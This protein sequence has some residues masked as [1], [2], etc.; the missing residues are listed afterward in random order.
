MTTAADYL[1]Y[2]KLRAPQ[3]SGEGLFEPAW[4]EIAPLVNENLVTRSE[5]CYDVHGKCLS[6]LAQEAREEMLGAARQWTASYRDIGDWAQRSSDRVFLAGHQPQMYH[7]GVWLKNFAL[8]RLA[9]EHDGVAVNLIVDSDTI[10]S[11]ALRVPGK[12]AE[13][14]NVVEIPYDSSGPMVPF[15]ER[16]ILDRQLF[17]SFSDRVER[18]IDSLVAEPLVGE[19]WRHVQ[20]R[21]RHCDR[22][23]L[24]LAQARHILEGEWGAQTLEL[25]QSVVCDSESYRWFLC[26]M[27]SEASRFRCIH[28]EV[29]AEYRRVHRIRSLA[30]P[31][32]DLAEQDGWCEAP[33]WVWTVDNPRRRRLFVQRVGDSIRVTDRRDLDFS[34]PMS[35][36]GDV[37]RAVECLQECHR[38]G[39]R[40]RSRAL[41]TTLWARLAL[42][43]LFVHGIGGA[44]YDQVTD[45]LIAGFFRLKPPGFLTVSGTL[46][47]PVPHRDGMA[48][49][50]GVLRERLRRL[51]FQPERYIEELEL[52]G[53]DQRGEIR[54]LISE[55]RDWIIKKVTPEN[56]RERFLSIRRLNDELQTWVEPLRE[57]TLRALETAEQAARAVSV[58]TWREYAFCL[59]PGDDLQDFFVRLLPK[60]A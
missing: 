13:R 23:G 36:E 60:R 33:F 1:G 12:T 9:E 17:G 19:Y 41:V 10:R 51:E 47:L 26:H 37:T 4:G 27:L 46:H 54:R 40:I 42:G 43:D 55:K 38:K 44:K 45:A 49:E 22:L 58:L 32:A 56:C 16:R 25:P 20:R 28:N 14:P 52:L 48:E 34:L 18:Q 2:R 15:E 53:E 8:S 24:C 31:V 11:H 57:K 29:V 39:I 6:R 3:E 35:R 5:A 59:Y 30:H 21:A 50:V 7:P